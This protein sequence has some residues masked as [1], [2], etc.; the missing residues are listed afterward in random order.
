M[1]TILRFD[2]GELWQ[3]AGWTMLHFAWIGGVVGVVAFA[4]WVITR[5][6]PANVRYVVALVCL[7]AMAASPGGVAA[8]LVVHGF[9]A[10]VGADTPISQFERIDSMKGVGTVLNPS[11][12][13]SVVGLTREL[14]A[15]GADQTSTAEQNPRPSRGLTSVSDGNTF[16]ATT[17]ILNSCARYLPWMWLIGAPLTF[18]VLTTGVVGAERL[19]RASRI[20]D[21]GPIVQACDRLMQAMHVTRRVTV[22]VC[23]RLAAPVLVGI[24]RPII[25]MPV[26]A[27]TYWS[28]DEIEMVLLHELAHVRRW[29]NLVNLGQRIVE[30]LL[31]FHPAVWLVS[32]WVRREREACC[33]AIVVDRTARPHA[34]AELLVALAAQMPRSVLFHPAASSAMAAGPLRG[35]IRRILQLEDDPMLVSGKSFIALVGSL[36]VAT[37]LGLLYLPARGQAKDAF[38][39]NKDLT[40][41]NTE[42]TGAGQE[43]INIAA[44]DRR[45]PRAGDEKL[46]EVPFVK[47]ASRFSDGDSITIREVRGTAATFEPG[48]IYWIKG[49]YTLGS[50]D[51]AA[52]SANTTARDAANGTSPT[53]KIQTTVVERGSGTF[54]LCLLMSSLGWPHLSFY[55]VDGGESFG[56]VYFGTGDSVLKQ[57]WGSNEAVDSTATKELSAENAEGAEAKQEKQTG[58]QSTKFPSLEEQKLADLAFRRLGLELEPLGEDDLKRVKVHGYGGGVRVSSAQTQLENGVWSGDLLVG[59]HVWP[60]TSLKEVAEVI[61][62]D[63]LAELNPLKFYVIRKLKGEDPTDDKD[64][65]VTGRISLNLGDDWQTNSSR[66]STSPAP[67]SHRVASASPE[68]IPLGASRTNDRPDVERDVDAQLKSDPNMAMLNQQLMQANYALS[69]LDSHSVGKD[70]KSKEADRLQKQIAAIEKQINDYRSRQALRAWRDDVERSTP[71]R[72]PGMSIPG[73]PYSERQSSQ[74][75]PSK[76]IAPVA[77]IESNPRLAALPELPPVLRLPVTPADPPQHAEIAVQRTSVDP[78]PDKA[79][80]ERIKQATKWKDEAKQELDDAKKQLIEADKGGD[81]YSVL[82]AKPEYDAAIQAYLDAKRALNELKRQAAE[83]QFEH[84]L[85]EL[86]QK[87]ST[88]EENAKSNMEEARRKREQAKRVAEAER[89]HSTATIEAG[90]LNADAATRA[91]EGDAQ[92]AEAEAQAKH[93]AE[94]MRREADELKREA[95]AQRREAEEEARRAQDEARREAEEVKREAEDAGR[96]ADDAK[97]QGDGQKRE[98]EEAARAQDVAKARD[99]GGEQKTPVIIMKQQAGADE[100]RRAETQRVLEQLHRQLE[101]ADRQ[102]EATKQQLEALVRQKEALAHQA[103]QLTRHLEQQSLLPEQTGEHDKP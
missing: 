60:T 75:S 36:I 65:F 62:R 10:S 90:P 95:E 7:G 6:A 77:P 20:I 3:L 24:V 74:L 86:R 58:A 61:S 15:S 89:R 73:N 25:L 103:E 37:T 78:R 42:G 9:V 12:P 5:R 67:K 56:G 71:G 70:G 64:I 68:P 21:D 94:E 48:N 33:D 81:K 82:A 98:A 34:Y 51:Q 99:S 80:A 102:L 97:R 16:D 22:A 32:S 23:E 8:W 27:L 66:R 49:T 91:A 38:T 92:V 57:W 47:G 41:E 29:D 43:I 54:T 55:P 31:F 83:L 63:D 59:L 52:L 2:G 30:S 69:T 14:T 87:I 46:V 44:A 72:M 13:V 88:R 79:L 101:Q 93:Q 76:P 28:V 26:G 96:E 100:R 18:V 35:R 11:G 53:W 40:T 39:S 19:R 45:D 84:E 1:N 85:G 17:A 50:H 4:C